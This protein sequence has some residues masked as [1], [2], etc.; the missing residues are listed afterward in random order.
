MLMCC[1][2]RGECASCASLYV[3]GTDARAVEKIW[4]T[5]Q[6][7]HAH[8]HTVYG[9][10]GDKQAFVPRSVYHVEQQTTGGGGDGRQIAEANICECVSMCLCEF[11][12]GYVCFVHACLSGDVQNRSLSNENARARERVVVVSGYDGSLVGGFGG[13]VGVVLGCG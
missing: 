10:L 4:V 8:K 1:Q 6:H 13:K 9:Q 11:V 5:S 2:A 7:T 3:C 12:C